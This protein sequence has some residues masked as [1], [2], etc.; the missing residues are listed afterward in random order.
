M[1]INGFHPLVAQYPLAHQV[2]ASAPSREPVTFGAQEAASQPEG[3]AKQK[4]AY[5]R[6]SMALL[7]GTAMLPFS[8]PSQ[9]EAAI[10]PES[11]KLVRLLETDKEEVLA[12]AL[13]NLSQVNERD[14]IPVLKKVLQDGRTSEDT[15]NAAIKAA[16][17]LGAQGSDK[18]AFSKLLLPYLL[19]VVVE[20]K[21][22]NIKF[23]DFAEAEFWVEEKPE[24]TKL[25]DGGLA[26]AKALGQIGDVDVLLRLAR[27]AQDGAQDFDVR[28]L[29]LEAIKH[30]PAHAEVDREVVKLYKRIAPETDAQLFTQASAILVRHNVSDGWKSLET[31]LLPDPDSLRSKSVLPA[32]SGVLLPGSNS[33][34]EKAEATPVTENKHKRP[35]LQTKDMGPLMF[36]LGGGDTQNEGLSATQ[37]SIIR[38]VLR[39]KNTDHAQLINRLMARHPSHFSRG[40]TFSDTV[41]FFRAM[42]PKTQE[43]LLE[44]VNIEKAEAL[45]RK[46]NPKQSFYSNIQAE[47]ADEAKIMEKA[48]AIRKVSLS[49][50][51]TLKMPEASKELTKLFTNTLEV[52]AL[53]HMAI[54]S[55]A[56]MKDAGAIKPLLALTTDDTEDIELRYDALA[57]V[58]DIATPPLAEGLH[59]DSGYEKAVARYMN[60]FSEN[61]K[62]TQSFFKAKVFSEVHDTRQA[63]L[64]ANMPQAVIDEA[65]NNIID[66]TL[67]R[68]K[69]NDTV[70]A[71]IAADPEFKAY[72]EGIVR[73]ISKE[74]DVDGFFRILNIIAAGE[75]GLGESNPALKELVLNPLARTNIPDIASSNDIMMFPGYT[76]QTVARNTRLASIQALGQTGTLKDAELMERGLQSDNR[77]LHLFAIS[78]LSNLGKNHATPAAD[79]APIQM[80]LAD[81]LLKRLPSVNLKSTDRLDNYF[82]KLYAE[83]IDN[84]GGTQKLIELM[85]TTSDTAL[86]RAIANGLIYNGKHLDNP[87]V[88][89]HLLAASMGLDKLHARGIDGR[90]T[91]VAIIDGDYINDDLEGLQGKVVYPTWGNTK[92]ASLRESFH[93]ESVASAIAGKHAS[94]TYGVA[95][96]VDKIYSYAAWDDDLT[97]DRNAP[98]EEVDGM[99][100]SLDDIIA[101]RISGESKVSVVNMSLGGT[102]ALLYG[103]EFIVK[104]FIQKLAAR[105]EAGHKAG[106]TFVIS[107]GNEGGANFFHHLMGTLNVLGFNK[108][109]GT[110]AQT[111]GVLLVG[112]SDTRGARER[113][114]HQM[115]SFSS[116]GDVFNAS[117]P[118]IVAPGANIPLV[119]REFNG[120]VNLDEMDG[121]SFSAPITAGT[122]L[123]MEQAHGKPLETE[124]IKKILSGTAYQLKDVPQFQQGNGGLDPVKAVEAAQNSKL[125]NDFN[126]FLDSL[127][128]YLKLKDKPSS[129]KNPEQN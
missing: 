81:K 3:K 84:L 108:E 76:K 50:V 17:R 15:L 33:G 112:A 65:L 101:K 100:R 103:D 18:A 52:P 129:A 82:R 62:F 56:A 88:T 51:S 41:A 21:D 128:A 127:G 30:A 45:A 89:Q 37:R 1:K 5:Y 23:L 104:E 117:Q 90:G 42:G 47:M 6:W 79:E 63:M 78:A 27:T 34:S 24:T 8:A 53:R 29:A 26:A 86:R 70:K 49:L 46:E 114:N 125:G 95:P 111:Q 35:S 40:D 73:Y 2:K 60:T 44:L 123:L 113:D 122:L 116:V 91:E 16:G 118:D 43:S 32:G 31:A 72:A 58:L 99:L 71:Q 38:E 54:A 36:L 28:W 61:P 119:N 9:L 121:T 57:A 19:K 4:S 67:S 115:A 39:Q 93:G 77:Q 80:A 69:L 12:A 55:S 98:L 94:L 75:A 83:A 22:K 120:E 74:K 48:R 107:A 106:I 10:T 126:Q 20:D 109:N 7:A 64:R 68:M 97:A 14:A 105:F 11:E 66:K 124:A 96:G 59:S 92:D 25:K 110:L 87:K 85:D 13:L 102:S